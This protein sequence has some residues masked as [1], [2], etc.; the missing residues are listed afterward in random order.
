MLIIWRWSWSLTQVYD[1]SCHSSFSYLLRHFLI[2][3]VLLAFK[4]KQNRRIL[5][6]QIAQQSSA[7]MAQ[8]GRFPQHRNGWVSFC[9]WPQWLVGPQASR[10]WSMLMGFGS[11]LSQQSEE[12]LWCKC[13]CV[14]VKLCSKEWF[15]VGSSSRG[16]RDLSCGLCQRSSTLQIRKTYLLVDTTWML[17]HSWCVSSCLLKAVSRSSGRVKPYCCRLFAVPF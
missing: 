12:C 3:F 17:R 2:V 4:K 7:A 11:K 8:V 16:Q 6:L 5:L 9:V 10:H 15:T 13:V 14:C 1:T